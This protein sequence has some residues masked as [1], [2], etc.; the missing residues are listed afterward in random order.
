ML[1][2]GGLEGSWVASGCVGAVSWVWVERVERVRVRFLLGFVSGFLG[3]G[4]H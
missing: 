4:M 3:V 2:R 1:E